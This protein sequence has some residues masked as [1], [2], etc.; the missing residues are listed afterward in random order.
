MISPVSQMIS[1]SS[2]MTSFM[3]PNKVEGQSLIRQSSSSLNLYSLTRSSEEN[4]SDKRQNVKNGSTVRNDVVLNDPQRSVHPVQPSNQM[5]PTLA[6]NHGEQ[7]ETRQ[8]SVYMQHSQQ[9]E[10]RQTSV[11]MQ[12]Q[13]QNLKTQQIYRN[14]PQTSRSNQSNYLDDNKALE[15]QRSVQLQKSHTLPRQSS[16]TKTYP[17]RLSGGN[18]KD[19]VY[20]LEKKSTIKKQFS[21]AELEQMERMERARVKLLFSRGTPVLKMLFWIVYLFLTLSIQFAIIFI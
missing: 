3:I 2:Q 20:A 9:N 21:E 11:Y 13:Q 7:N 12:Q 1:T 4:S 8:T 5:R 6:L 15:N 14:S 10:T 16:V 17:Q 19:E 18:S